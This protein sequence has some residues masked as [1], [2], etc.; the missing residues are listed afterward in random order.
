M[1]CRARLHA[2]DPVKAG[3]MRTTEQAK[4][5]QGRVRAA[6]PSRIASARIDG[7][8]GHL[9]VAGSGNHDIDV[10]TLLEV[11]IEDH[12]AGRAPARLGHLGEPAILH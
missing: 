10:A 4:H 6:R 1:I 5:C 8:R 12:L 7:C 9:L 3:A 2:G 11:G